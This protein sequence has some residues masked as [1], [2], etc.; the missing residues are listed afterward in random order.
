MTVKHEYEPRTPVEFRPAW[1]RADPAIE[2]DAE[3]FWR[4]EGLLPA[5]ANIGER[6][7]ELCLAGYDGE[8]LIALTTARIRYID[9][10]GV[11]LAMLRVATA[12]HNRKNR[13]ATIIQAEARALLEQ[14]SADNPAEEVMGM[15]TV[16]QTHAFDGLGPARGFLRAS[17]LGFVGWTANGE[18]M[19]VAWFDDGTIPRQ[20]PDTPLSPR[21]EFRS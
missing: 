15:G 8:E 9:F 17:H 19:R 14:W 12:S 10:L 3:L 21:E 20:R 11:K 1:R 6:L 7:S 13:L 16:T 18:A 4:R 5:A 2:R